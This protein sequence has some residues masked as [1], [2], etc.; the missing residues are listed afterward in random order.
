[1]K[2]AQMV[3]P[4]I[5]VEVI[6]HGSI[7]IQFT[8]DIVGTSNWKQFIQDCLNSQGYERGYS[9]SLLLDEACECGHSHLTTSNLSINFILV[10]GN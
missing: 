2:S 9:L 4:Q 8:V 6:E 7:Q 1:M 10:E 3:R 5:K